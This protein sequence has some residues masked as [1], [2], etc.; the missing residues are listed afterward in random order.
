[1]ATPADSYRKAT[2]SEKCPRC[3]DT[4]YR[5]KVHGEAFFV[6]A[7]TAHGMGG[8]C[9]AMNADPHLNLKVARSGHEVVIELPERARGERFVV[10]SAERADEVA[11]ALMAAAVDARRERQGVW[12]RPGCD[13]PICRELRARST[14]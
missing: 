13:C 9:F 5:T 11:A 1:M 2:G 7:T 6:H 10:M 4:G 12:A 3:G 8:C 14:R